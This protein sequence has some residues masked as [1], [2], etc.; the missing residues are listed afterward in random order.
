M[1]ALTQSL[2]SH[3]LHIADDVKVKARHSISLETATLGVE[4]GDNSISLFIW[5]TP[6]HVSDTLDEIIRAAE[7]L[8]TDIATRAAGMVFTPA[9]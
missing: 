2:S 1:P 7:A 8:K 6:D 5:G 9:S 3:T 4:A